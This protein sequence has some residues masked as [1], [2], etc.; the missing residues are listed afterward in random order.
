MGGG[1]GGVGRAEGGE[2]VRVG[3]GKV[4]EGARVGSTFRCLIS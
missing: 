2:G 3:R 4:G 1:E